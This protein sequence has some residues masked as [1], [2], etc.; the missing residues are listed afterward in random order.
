MHL[1][2]RQHKYGGKDLAVVEVEIIEIFDGS[3]E[4]QIKASSS[5]SPKYTQKELT[6]WFSYV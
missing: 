3:I 4:K 2:E 5:S 6:C 1:F